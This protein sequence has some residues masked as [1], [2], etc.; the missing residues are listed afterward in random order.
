MIEMADEFKED[1][2]RL[3][4]I[5]KQREQEIAQLQV[6]KQQMDNL[7]RETEKD[8]SKVIGKLEYISYLRSSN[9]EEE[10]SE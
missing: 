10:G 2:E 7:I 5:K 9:N 4:S 3:I 1:E 8:L 6:Q